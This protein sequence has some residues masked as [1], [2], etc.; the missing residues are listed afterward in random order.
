MSHGPGRLQRAILEF[1]RSYA[2]ATQRTPQ[3]ERWSVDGLAVNMRQFYG[4]R[5]FTALSSR[6]RAD[7]RKRVLRA[8]DGLAR[9]GMVVR[10]GPFWMLPPESEQE[11]RAR[12]KRTR[13]TARQDREWQKTRGSALHFEAAKPQIDRG[14]RKLLVNILGQLGSSS[15]NVVV[16]AAHQAERLRADSVSPGPIC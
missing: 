4:D 5:P 9:A 8:C 10:A 16:T 14:T 13:T 7:V 12:R 3:R 11:A 1:I 6:E 15:D 2:Q